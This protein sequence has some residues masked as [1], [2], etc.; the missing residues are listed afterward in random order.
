MTSTFA[1]RVEIISSWKGNKTNERKAVLDN[2]V[3][4]YRLFC[5]IQL[6]FPRHHSNSM[7]DFSET[8]KAFS[9]ELRKEYFSVH[10]GKDLNLNNLGNSPV[11][12]LL[13]ASIIC[14]SRNHNSNL[15]MISARH[16]RQNFL[17]HLTNRE[18]LS[19]QLKVKQEPFKLEFIKF[20]TTLLVL[21]LYL[22]Q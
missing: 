3:V 14:W 19:S 1:L 2:V 21:F 22:R 15:C 5:W 4:F 12:T 20:R 9:F 11:F 13:E 10:Y 18:Y 6:S 8:A 7:H 16:Q 17:G